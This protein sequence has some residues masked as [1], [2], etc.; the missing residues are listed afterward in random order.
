MSLTSPFYAVCAGINSKVYSLLNNFLSF[1]CKKRRV[2]LSCLTTLFL[3]SLLV[4]VFLIYIHEDS[5]KEYISYLFAKIG[6]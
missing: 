2:Q 6:N 5:N 1:K 3:Y 4:Q